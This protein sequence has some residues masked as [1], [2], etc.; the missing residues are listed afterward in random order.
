[1]PLMYSVQGWQPVNGWK[2]RGPV[3]GDWIRVRE[4]ISKDLWPNVFEGEYGIVLGEDDL[5]IMVH[6]GDTREI[7]YFSVDQIDWVCP[8]KPQGYTCKGCA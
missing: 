4:G 5:G 7:T 6:M 2:S 3:R 8:C 1:M